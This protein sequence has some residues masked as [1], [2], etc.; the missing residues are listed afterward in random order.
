[1]A[2]LFAACLNRADAPLQTGTSAARRSLA[3]RASPIRPAATTTTSEP[4]IPQ[5]GDAVLGMAL[6]PSSLNPFLEETAADPTL[7]LIG[8]AVWAGVQTIEADTLE[9]IPEVVTELPS[10]ENGDLRLNEDGTMT[11]RYRIRPE[12]VWEDGSPIT[13][14]DFEFTYQT[15]VNPRNPIRSS[16]RRAYQAIVP[17]SVKAEEKTFEY[18]L[19]DPSLGYEFLFNVILP[20][21][22]VEGSSFARDWRE[23]MWMAAGPFRFVE[24][25]KGESILLERNPEYW[26]EDQ[27][28][29]DR[30]P[31]LEEVEFRFIP[32]PRDLIVAFKR[33]E[34]DVINPL[35]RLDFIEELAALEGEGADVQVRQGPA[36][37]HL[38]F[39][40]G[41]GRFERNPESLNQ[42]VE[43]RRA[44]AHL[45]DRPAIAQSIL[46]GALG[47]LHSFI[48]LYWPGASQDAWSRYD[49]DPRRARQL[50][51]EL[52]EELGRDFT[53]EPPQAV[54]TTTNEPERV[55]LAEMLVRMLGEGGIEVTVELEERAL[56]FGN[57]VAEG[58]WDIGEWAWI[59]RQGRAG[60]VRSLQELFY[61]RP[62]SGLNYYR[63]SDLGE[64]N[65]DAQR[66]QEIL[67]GL[68]TVVD[69]QEL[70]TQILEV[71]RILADQV[72]IIPLYTE[73]DVGVVWADEIVGYE[74]NPTVAGDTWN[75]EHWYRPSF[76]PP[77]LPTG[78]A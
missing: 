44:I 3:P 34:V 40:F 70:R 48:D 11:V 29:G 42:Y 28:T 61:L 24:W 14:S 19:A 37:E 17:G 35:P 1:M 64:P 13:G 46:Q 50:I 52:G 36:W 6:E 55:R 2:L 31:Y 25:N 9:F 53:E 22:Q 56:F 77:D 30:L 32:D 57:S 73:P 49:H 41:G 7:P 66:A 23:T 27:A 67:A 75:I 20:R 58:T 78:G 72:V 59:A 38:N 71:E 10:V 45:V 69:E 26:K 76:E 4:G 65:P 68:D 5:G 8:Q 43:Y 62:P 74:H 39:Q 54:F 63:W 51:D 47:P 18:L 33:R 21:A 12:A 15:I 16:L 60:L